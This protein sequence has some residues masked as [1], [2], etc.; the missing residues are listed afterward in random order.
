MRGLQEH[1]VGTSGEGF[2]SPALDSRQYTMTRMLPSIADAGAL[3]KQTRVK[4]QKK[5]R[6]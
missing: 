1:A 3:P 5:K 2:L 6:K 4:R